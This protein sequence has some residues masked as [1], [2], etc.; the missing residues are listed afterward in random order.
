ME[1]AFNKVNNVCRLNTYQEE[2]IKYI[3]QDK[4]DIFVSR[5]TGFAN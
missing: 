4:K 2:S 5:L 3:V 1:R